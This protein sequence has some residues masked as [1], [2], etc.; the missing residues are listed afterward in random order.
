MITLNENVTLNLKMKIHHL[1]EK[2]VVNYFDLIFNRYISIWNFIR[3]LLCQM[4]TTVCCLSLSTNES[5]SKRFTWLLWPYV[6]NMWKK[7]FKWQTNKSNCWSKLGKSRENF[8]TIQHPFITRWR[9]KTLE[10]LSFW[11]ISHL[12]NFIFVPS[13]ISSLSQS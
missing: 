9:E 11:N 13:I 8:T 3:L 6:E 10:I 12:G 2:F 7:L 4:S 1:K 5:S